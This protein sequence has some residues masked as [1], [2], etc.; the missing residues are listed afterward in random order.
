MRR[1][2]EAIGYERVDLTPVDEIMARVHLLD[3][4]Q[5]ANFEGRV[6]SRPT[7]LLHCLTVWGYVN[8][9]SLSKNLTPDIRAVARRLWRLIDRCCATSKTCQEPGSQRDHERPAK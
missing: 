8:K 9:D 7:V 4:A 6:F 2:S 3:G 5:R 1:K